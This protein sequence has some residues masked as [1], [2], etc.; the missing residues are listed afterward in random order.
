MNALRRELGRLA[1]VD[2]HDG[3]LHQTR[4]QFGCGQRPV[5]PCIL[6]P[7]S[8]SRRADGP[9]RFLSLR[10]YVITNILS[11]IATALSTP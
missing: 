1:H 2:K 7:R 4:R 8:P 6:H 3:A 9:V 10:I 11:T 5:W